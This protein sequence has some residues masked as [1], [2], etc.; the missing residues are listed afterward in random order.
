MTFDEAEAV[1]VYQCR[2]AYPVPRAAA[3]AAARDWAS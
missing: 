3:Q 1:G 2:K